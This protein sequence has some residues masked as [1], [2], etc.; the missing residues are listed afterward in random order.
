[1]VSVV[2]RVIVGFGMA[3]G[4]F[5]VLVVNFMI[6]VLEI[7][8]WGN[9]VSFLFSCWLVVVNSSNFVWLFCSFI[10][11]SIKAGCVKSS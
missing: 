1:V 11:V 10:S 3:W 4:Q 5:S 8:N 9:F 7:S 2:L 6:V